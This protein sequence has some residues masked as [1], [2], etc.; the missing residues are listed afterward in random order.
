MYNEN[1]G[2]SPISEQFLRELE[3]EARATREC[4]QHVP[5][6]KPDWKPHEKSMAL[7]Y[8]AILVAEIPRWLQSMIEKGVVDFQTWE[9]KSPKT[10]D[11]LVSLFD[12]N[13][14]AARR[15]FATLT[16]DG[17][18]KEFVLKNGDQIYITTP[19]G[20]SISSSINHMVHHR[21]QLTV[22]LKLLDL[23]IPSIYG[24]SADAGG[25]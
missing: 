19:V 23:P 12:A 14:D 7:G 16:D 18:Q 6:G 15:A 21:G 20:E 8:L 17:L 24:P 22:Y 1:G 3:A 9:Q 13:M 11:E 10:A 5:M 25:F 2:S 4:L